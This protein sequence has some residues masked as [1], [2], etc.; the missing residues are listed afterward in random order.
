MPRVR[1]SESRPLADRAAPLIEDA[2]ERSRVSMRTRLE[3]LRLA[4]R[5]VLQAGSR[6]ASPG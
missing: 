6:P 1:D 4:W 2:A 5:S 3:R